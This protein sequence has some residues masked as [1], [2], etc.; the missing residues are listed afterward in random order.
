MVITVHC[1]S[2]STAFPVDTN[3][4]PKGGVYARCSECAGVFFVERPEEERVAAPLAE[5]GA[6][7]YQP[8]PAPQVGKEASV[9]F[10]S[11][12]Q[13]PATAREEEL[14]SDPW[15]VGAAEGTETDPWSPPSYDTYD[16]AGDARSDTS[17]QDPLTEA[18]RDAG[19]G[20]DAWAPRDTLFVPE[21]PATWDA[22]VE[23]AEPA[24][25]EQIIPPPSD[26]PGYVEPS[27]TASYES[28]E[29]VEVEVYPPAP[30]SGDTWRDAIEEPNNDT[31]EITEV[32]QETVYDEAPA[33]SDAV[34]LDEPYSAPPPFGEPAAPVE[35]FE[36][37][38]ATRAATTTPTWPPAEPPVSEA[39]AA[40]PPSW[41]PTPEPPRAP[42]T[43]ATE[44]AATSFSFGRRDPH[45]KARRLARVLVSDMIMYN[46]ERHTRAIQ[47]GSLRQDFDDEIRK[48][49]Q[50]YVEQVG[51]EIAN[52]TSYFDDALNDILAR[53]QRVFP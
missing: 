3:K 41:A 11:G 43:S 51:D 45:E 16:R 37:A 20:L 48:S 36:D 24:G 35:P 34:T 32:Y 22:P 9:D 6:P 23:E 7:S 28:V 53:G 31:F 46:P 1:P 40:A 39:P 19:E 50:E 13:E 49:W 10:A 38:S 2:C 15:R 52:S 4:V 27:F 30:I 29:E 12:W 14:G 42:V 5:G 47:S 26:E 18:A 25:Q 33:A 17:F 21:A 8:P 44:A